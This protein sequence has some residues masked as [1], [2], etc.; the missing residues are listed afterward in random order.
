MTI[1]FSNDLDTNRLRIYLK[2]NQ[3]KKKPVRI[4]KPQL[5]CIEIY[6]C[7]FCCFLGK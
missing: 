1:T 3:R 7:G 2:A 5:H 6:Q 4:E